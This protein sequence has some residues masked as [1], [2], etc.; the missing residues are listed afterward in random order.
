MHHGEDTD[1]YVKKGFRVIA[2]EADPDLAAR[3][4]RKFSDQIEKGKVT[5]VEGAIVPPSNAKGGKTIK[6][7]KNNDVDVWGTVVDQRDAK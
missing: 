5:I 2:F 7:Y 6:F 3:C 4:R 1:H